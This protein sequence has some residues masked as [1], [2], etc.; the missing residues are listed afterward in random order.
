[1]HEKMSGSFAVFGR[2]HLQEMPPPS[3]MM[4]NL[5]SFDGDSPSKCNVLGSLIMKSVSLTLN[6]TQSRT[7]T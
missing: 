3:V 6:S 1:M 5:D 4:K 2:P 7:H